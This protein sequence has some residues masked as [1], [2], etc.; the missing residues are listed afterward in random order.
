MVTTTYKYTEYTE[1]PYHYYTSLLTTQL[2]TCMNPSVKYTRVQLYYY[3]TTPPP[4]CMCL[5][6]SYRKRATA[7]RVPQT[8]SFQAQ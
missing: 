8:G 1:Q 6:W 5:T 7:A 3:L 4:T 2:P